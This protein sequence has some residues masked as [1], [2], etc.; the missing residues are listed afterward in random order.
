[1]VI[2]FFVVP[3]AWGVITLL[4]AGA[5]VGRPDCPWLQLDEDGEEAH[6]GQMQQGHTCLL[7]YKYHGGDSTGTATYRQRK[8]AQEVKRREL[9]GQGLLYTLYGAAGTATTVI[10]TR[11][12]R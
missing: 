3:L 2:A 10:A 7:D 12:R 6:P 4:W 9:L 1:M 5:A 11:S 8:Y